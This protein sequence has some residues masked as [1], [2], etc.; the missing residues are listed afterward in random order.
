MEPIWSPL[1]QERIPDS[2][3]AWVERL[4]SELHTAQEIVDF[5][6]PSDAATIFEV[7]SNKAELETEKDHHHHACRIHLQPRWRRALSFKPQTDVGMETHA[8]LTANPVSKSSSRKCDGKGK[9]NVKDMTCFLCGVKSHNVADCAPY[10]YSR[11]T[12]KPSKQH[13]NI[14]CCRQQLTFPA[15]ERLTALIANITDSER[16]SALQVFTRL[17][18]NANTATFRPDQRRLWMA[19]DS[20]KDT[21]HSQ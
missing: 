17:A 19:V 4:R 2:L 16:N 13:N 8:N 15:F 7:V 11:N 14:C 10:S 1:R 9:K 3:H 18:I 5:V 12:S 6:A 21:S 20:I